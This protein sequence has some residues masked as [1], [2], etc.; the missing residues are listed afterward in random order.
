M[1]FSTRVYEVV[2]RIPKGKTLSYAEVAKRAGNSRAARAVG[3]IL[4]RNHNSAI[5]CHRVIKSDGSL[6]GYNQGIKKKKENPRR[7]NAKLF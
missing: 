5:P 6:G 2:K 3:S 4:S 7:E 1:L